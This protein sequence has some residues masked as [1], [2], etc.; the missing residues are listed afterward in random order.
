MV[1]HS[2][3]VLKEGEYRAP[4]FSFSRQTPNKKKPPGPLSQWGHVKD[5]LDVP[6]VE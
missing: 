1:E 2:H 6:V 4:V 3:L 5:E